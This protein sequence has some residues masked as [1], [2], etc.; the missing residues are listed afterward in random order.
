[1]YHVSQSNR[2]KHKIWPCFQVAQSSEAKRQENEQL[3]H[4]VKK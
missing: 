1:M 2:Q 4:N 3:K